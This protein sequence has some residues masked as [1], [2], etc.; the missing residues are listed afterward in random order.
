MK[1]DAW[2]ARWEIPFLKDLN[3]GLPL[4]QSGIPVETGHLSLFMLV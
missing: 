1:K 2:N 3:H 4:K